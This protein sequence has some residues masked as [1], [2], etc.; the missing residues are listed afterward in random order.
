MRTAGHRLEVAHRVEGDDDVA[1]TADDLIEAQHDVAA[2]QLEPFV[3]PADL[4][5]R[6]SADQ[7]AGAG[8]GQAVAVPAD[9][10]QEAVLVRSHPG[11]E[12]GGE[13][14]R[15]DHH[16]AVLDAA[17][18]GPMLEA[19]SPDAL[20]VQHPDR[21]AQPPRVDDLGVVVQEDEHLACRAPGGDRVDP[22]IVERFLAPP[23]VPEVEA[24]FERLVPGLVLRGLASVVHHGDVERRVVRHAEA[25][26]EPLEIGPGM[27]RGHNDGHARPGRPEEAHAD[28]ATADTRL[29]LLAPFAQRLL[30]HPGVR[31]GGCAAGA[32]RRRQQNMRDQPD[33]GVRQVCAQKELP[34]A[35]VVQRHIGM[36]G[37]GS[38][39]DRESPVQIVGPEHDLGRPDRA[40]ARCR[41]LARQGQLIGVECDHPAHRI[42]PV[43]F[44]HLLQCGRVEN[45]ASREEQGEVLVRPG[46]DLAER[47]AADG[48]HFAD[49]N[50]QLR[51][52]ARQGPRDRLP[53][54][55]VR[56]RG[57]LDDDEE[58]RGGSIVGQRLQ[59]GLLS[60]PLGVV[61]EAGPD[62]ARNLGHRRHEGVAERDRRAATRAKH[63]PGSRLGWHDRPE[64]ASGAAHPAVHPGKSS[65]AGYS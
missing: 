29:R 37:G 64:T 48:P 22:R 43:L 11:E 18:L 28:D 50:G 42:D 3:E 65:G 39:R 2:G 24:R 46:Q 63:T 26:Q 30:H 36:L 55:V 23:H 8:D 34:D 41:P 60:A 6:L 38:D 59:H 17:V 52:D 57:R 45:G 1:A 4:L 62:D 40:E 51:P 20:A 9:R 25:R 58:S 54:P 35:V 27:P 7:H 15:A 56:L 33:D 19:H 21:F 13:T 10:P 31:F 47:G 32:G 14:A 61:G 5:E 12:I 16:A 49:P 53:L 44:R